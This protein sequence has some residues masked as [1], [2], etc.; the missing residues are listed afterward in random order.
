MLFG[1]QKSLKRSTKLYVAYMKVMDATKF[2][3]IIVKCAGRSL[4][5]CICRNQVNKI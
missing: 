3:R 2:S 4:V 1:L 5:L